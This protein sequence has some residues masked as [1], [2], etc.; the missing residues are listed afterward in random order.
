MNS[1]NRLIAIVEHFRAREPN[2]SMSKAWQAFLGSD[3]NA[4]PDEPTLIA[5]KVLQE[6]KSL[7]STLSRMGV[8]PD[9]YRQALDTL[10]SAWSP[11]QLSQAWSG[12]QESVTRVG[13]VAVLHWAAWATRAQ[14]DPVVNDELFGELLQKLHE[15]EALLSRTDLPPSIQEMLGR[16]VDELR[17]AVRFYRITGVKPIVD[18]V[19]RQVGEIRTAPAD[20]ADE[21]SAST[22]EA[23]GAFQKGLELLA[24]AGK[25]ADSGSKI[26][27]FGQDL[28]KYGSVG[29]ES[30]VKLIGTAPPPPPGL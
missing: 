29:W 6:I 11:T 21:L 19:H 22:A 25:V 16:H 18:A 30:A 17:D 15:Q 8:P 7:D 10:K 12:F 9:A 14:D 26:A 4:D 1:A 27:K 3:A 20:V 24:V 23:K 13:T 28:Y 5:T 2:R